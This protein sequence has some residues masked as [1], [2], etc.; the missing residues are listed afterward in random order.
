[1]TR[2]LPAAL[3]PIM[4]FAGCATW[5]PRPG[6]TVLARADEQLTAGS[7]GRALELYDQFLETQGQDVAAPRARATRTVLS[8]WLTTQTTLERL[9]ETVATQEQA[10]AERQ[11]EMERFRTDAERFKTEAERFKTDAERLKTETER[12]RAETERLKIEAERLKTERERL[13]VDL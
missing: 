2:R 11:R 5:L 3:L 1:M 9:R 6:G 7:Y 4:V 10:L 12:F 13:R 8:R